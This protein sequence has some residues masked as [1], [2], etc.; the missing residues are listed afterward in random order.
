[1]SRVLRK[2]SPRWSSHAFGSLAFAAD[3][4][5]GVGVA[6][7]GGGAGAIAAADREV[8]ALA[9]DGA[10]GST[11]CREDFPTERIV[12]TFFLS[13]LAWRRS[14][15]RGGGFDDSSTLWVGDWAISRVGTAGN[16]WCHDPGA[17]LSSSDAGNGEAAREANSAGGAK[18][19]GLGAASVA[20]AFSA[21]ASPGLTATRE[22]LSEREAP[23]TSIG[24]RL[25]VTVT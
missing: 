12:A 18:F 2:S 17:S 14:T 16:P 15:G 5:P 9:E 1:M 24:T 7:A 6:A 8:G 13:R 10:G 4:V 20:S 23:A 22:P 3:A 25:T 11:R 21:T 19:I